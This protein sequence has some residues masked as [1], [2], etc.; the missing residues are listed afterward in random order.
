MMRH[1]KILII[2]LL[3]INSISLIAFPP[4]P[5]HTFT[6]LVRDEMGKPLEGEKVEVFFE[7]TSGNLIKSRVE[8]L[9]PGINY[10]LRIPMDSGATGDL[11]DS[12]AMMT[13]MTYKIR[14]KVDNNFY[15]PIEF[16]GDFSKI[17]KPGDVT[18]MNLTLGEDADGD[19][20]PDAW[21]RSLL[22][23]GKT[24]KDIRP[25]DDID[26]D[27]MSNLDEYISGN[28][29]FDKNDGL[30]LDINGST[31]DGISLEFIG[32]R[33][34]TYTLHGTSDLKIWNSLS[35]S[36]NGSEDVVENLRPDNV[37][38]YKI[39]VSKE[40]AGAS[41]KFFKLMVQ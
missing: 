6:G 35:F 31:K 24:I 25:D 7:T 5:H 20:L 10:E 34:R 19:G 4:A 38:N 33:G 28:Y 11:Y 15:L 29:A 23:K 2:L 27:G 14:V 30:R 37:K 39:N 26:G 40:H 16:F 9:A 41:I 12:V 8:H 13:A 21:E 32:L 3:L 18:R 1:L 22:S 17:G 36:I